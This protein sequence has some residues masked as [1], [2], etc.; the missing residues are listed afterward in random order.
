M[1]EKGRDDRKEI[2][3]RN[4]VY[5]EGHEEHEGKKEGKEERGRDGE[6]GP[7]RAGMTVEGRD[8]EEAEWEYKMLD[9]SGWFWQNWE[10]VARR[11]FLSV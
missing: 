9:L 3:R 1:T 5:H 11:L 7:R 2:Q 10:V 4:G 6:D 8:D